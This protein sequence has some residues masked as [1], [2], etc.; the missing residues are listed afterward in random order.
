MEDIGVTV[1]QL[2]YKNS[3][4]SLCVFLPDTYDGLAK[5]EADMIT[6]NYTQI[7]NDMNSGL[8]K[9]SF[10]KFEIDFNA[11]LKNTLIQVRCYKKKYFFIYFK[12]SFLAWIRD[13]IQ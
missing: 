5:L 11:S 7:V 13:Y 8:V 10:P 9:M 4:M 6:F 3:A 2:D 12:Y 1:A